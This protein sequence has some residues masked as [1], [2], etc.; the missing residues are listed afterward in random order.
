[1]AEL[2]TVKANQW[3]PKVSRHIENTLSLM[4]NFSQHWR[5][6]TPKN[7][8]DIGR[9]LLRT[10]IIG[11]YSPGKGSWIGLAFEIELSATVA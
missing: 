10:T 11:P 8:R 4:G 5:I 7:C 9:L 3:K 1:M 6:F 2:E